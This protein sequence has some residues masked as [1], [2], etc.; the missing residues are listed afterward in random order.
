MDFQKIA[1]YRNKHN[2]FARRLGIT[3]EEVRQGYAR[4]VK[5]V[6]ADDVNPVQVAHGGIYFTM[7]DAACAAAISV[8]G[9]AAVTLNATCNFFSSAR[10]GDRLI[11]EATE[12]SN[13]DPICVYETQVIGSNGTVYSSGTMTFYKL[14]KKL[15]LES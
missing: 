10:V 9:Y 6:E 12:I 13:E 3:I 15:N 8:H 7:A 14:N 1:D 5:T 4:A 2:L 11:A